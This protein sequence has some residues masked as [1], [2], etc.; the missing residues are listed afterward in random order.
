MKQKKEAVDLVSTIIAGYAKHFGKEITRLDYLPDKD[1]VA[2]IIS[3]LRKLL[4]P[5]Y[6]NKGAADSAGINCAVEALAA[7]IK[8]K[9]NR[10][11]CRTLNL[12]AGQDEKCYAMAGKAE[13]LCNA[14][15][16]TIPG[17]IEV[18]ST[19]VQATY[20]GDPA[21]KN[22][23]EIIFTYPGIFAISIYR[24]AHQLHLLSVPL[25]PRMM[26][27]HAHSL[28]GIDIH[29]GAD[30]GPYF[31]IDHGT[32]IVIGETTKIGSHVKLYQGVT[33]GAL[34]TQGGQNLRSKKRHPTL[35]DNVVIYSG[36][37]IL[38]GE[39]VIGKGSVI[40]GNVF[41]TQSVQ[42]N[43]KVNVKNHELEYKKRK[44]S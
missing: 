34:S 19:D 36:A 16:Q 40:G 3:L 1:E 20:D 29:P 32:G 2:D 42:S 24:L 30:I 18:L 15:L 41:I 14:F 11:I 35:E 43:T 25:I 7:D 33:I 17:I 21:A 37:T 12:D 23:H 39:T 44:S 4:F 10:Q 22:K 31:C 28:T 5:G 6:F 9:L 13:E 26:T 8:M 27:E 38:G